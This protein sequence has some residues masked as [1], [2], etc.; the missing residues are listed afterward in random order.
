[1]G[2]LIAA[3]S[4]LNIYTTF[5]SSGLAGVFLLLFL[6]G[7]IVT[8]ASLDKETKAREA[9]DEW[10]K[11]EAIPLVANMATTLKDTTALLVELKRDRDHYIHWQDG[12][13]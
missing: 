9:Q 4:D 12:S 2:R 10:L 5:A 1:M 3:T 6:Q 7:K 13:Q 8:G 11:T